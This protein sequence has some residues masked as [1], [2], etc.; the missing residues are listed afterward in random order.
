MKNLTG[1]D[2]IYNMLFPTEPNYAQEI[3][4]YMKRSDI[5]T[6]I[7]VG[8]NSYSVHSEKVSSNLANDIAKSVAPWMTELLSN[9]RV[10]IYNGQLDITIAYPMT[11][12]FLQNLN[13]NGADQYKTA[14]RYKWYVKSDLA[15][16][17]KQAGNL[18]E[19]LIRNAGHRVPHDQPVWAL[20]L[21]LKFTRNKPF[22]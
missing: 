19:V 11:V 22:H 8:K 4:M 7:H 5:R 10:L 12:N 1:F 9:Y 15:G 13:F 3:E 16:Y 2:N 17:V 6:A 18:T 20:D 14:T 21:I